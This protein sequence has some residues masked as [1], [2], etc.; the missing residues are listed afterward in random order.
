MVMS[1]TKKE[2]VTFDFT[3]QNHFT[4]AKQDSFKI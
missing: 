1:S 4:H 3:A 2:W